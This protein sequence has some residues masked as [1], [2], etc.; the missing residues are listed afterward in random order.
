VAGKKERQRKLAA[1]RHQRRLARRA[2]RDRRATRVTV[3]ITAVIV[4]AGL[5]VGGVLLA[6]QSSGTTTTPKA[7]PSAL[8]LHRGRDGRAQGEPPV[9]HAEL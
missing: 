4:V 7:T 6:G 8:R 9:S 5:S 1:E 3:A 2:Q